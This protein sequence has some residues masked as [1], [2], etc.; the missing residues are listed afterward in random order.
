MTNTQYLEEWISESGKKKEYLSD[1]LGISR[2]ALRMKI[3]NQT[4]FTAKEIK[5][6]CDELGITKL[7]D[8]ERIFL[9]IRCTKMYT[10]RRNK[11]EKMSTDIRLRPIHYACVSGGKDSLYMLG[12]ILSNLDK[13]PLDCVVHYQLEI[14]WEW[15]NKAVDEMEERCSKIGIP[16]YRIKPTHSW[17]ELYQKWH[18][19]TRVARWCNSDYK[20]DCERQLKKWV[21]EQNCRPIAYI[22][23]CAD[24]TKRFKYQVGEENWELGTICYPLA[25]EG[26]NEDLILEWAKHQPIFGD[27]YKYFRRQGC[28][29]CPMMSKKE[30]AYLKKNEPHYFE[31]YFKCVFEYEEH[32]K[33]PYFGKEWGKDIKKRVETKWT[34]I[35]EMEEQ[36]L[37]VFDFIN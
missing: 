32:F 36:Q 13:Y 20:L 31:F 29:L 2:Q 18:M 19:P 28:K 7:S 14:D 6:L 27:W 10:E 34:S 33:R 8:K 12:L 15:A 23:L 25:E 4:D 37:S 16:F 30:L 17:E 11:K 35:L 1:K 21:K 22:G 5:I 26:I 24:E 9:L 3:I